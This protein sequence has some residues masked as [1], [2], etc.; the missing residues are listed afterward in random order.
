MFTCE[1]RYPAR[2]VAR[3]GQAGYPLSRARISPC[4]RLTRFEGLSFKVTRHILAPVAVN[5]TA[6]YRG[7]S[8]MASDSNEEAAN[9]RQI[10]VT[11]IEEMENEPNTSWLLVF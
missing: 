6:N 7:H 8:E 3:L 9:F 10:S 2:R 11:S 5:S 4:K 1:P